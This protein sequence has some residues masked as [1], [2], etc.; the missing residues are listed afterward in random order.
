MNGAL[1]FPRLGSFRLGFLVCSNS[2]LSG[3]PNSARSA[4]PVPLRLEVGESL[5]QGW[6]VGAKPPHGSRMV[7]IELFDY[8]KERSGSHVCFFDCFLRRLNKC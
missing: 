7:D 1:Y 3:M 6:M 4:A 2:A 8:D 5:S